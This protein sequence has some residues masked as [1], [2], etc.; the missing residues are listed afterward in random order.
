MTAVTKLVIFWFV[1]AVIGFPVVPSYPFIDDHVSCAI[2]KDISPCSCQNYIPLEET[3]RKPW[4]KVTCEKMNSF[5][6]V[7]QTLQNKFDRNVTIML[8]I[9]FSNLDDLPSNKF[10][11]INSDINELMLNH[12]NLM[13]I[14]GFSFEGIGNVKLLSLADNKISEFPGMIFKHMPYI[15][16]LEVSRTHIKYISPPDF[17]SLQSLTT[18]LFSNC[19]LTVIQK[20]TFPSKLKI[21]FLGSNNLTTLNQNLRFQENITVIDLQNNHIKL[22]DG[23]LPDQ[24]PSSNLQYLDISSNEIDYIPQSFRNLVKLEHLLASRNKLTILNNTLQKLPCLLD[25]DVSRNQIRTLYSTDFSNTKLVTLNLQYNEITRL[26]GSL[27]PLVNLKNLT[28]SYNNMS[29]L[30]MSEFKGLLILKDV[31]LSHNKLFKIIG[32]EYDTDIEVHITQLNLAYNEIE[33]LEG[34]LG[35]V[36]ELTTLSLSHNKLRHLPSTF[37]KGLDSLEYL[38]VSYNFLSSLE[39]TSKVILHSLSEINITHNELTTLGQDF[40]GFP[41]LCWAHLSHNKI[42]TI[43]TEFTERTQC[44]VYQ[45]KSTLRIYLEGNAVLCDDSM[46]E[47]MKAIETRSNSTEFRGTAYCPAPKEELKYNVN[48]SDS[49]PITVITLDKK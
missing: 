48:V 5:L 42:R 40:H 16:T 8:Q 45:V 28:V 24:I 39:D 33:V 31:D 3:K 26:N 47:V 36:S 25:L 43:K 27:L 1:Y 13:G 20:G 32:F 46:K 18:L 21:V 41:S 22:L 10:K 23:E 37:L 29:E 49:S 7:V 14:T 34:S 11:H 38:D 2:R 35:A 9:A 15:E 17:E 44:K 19:N 4:I 30:S 12:N 6:E